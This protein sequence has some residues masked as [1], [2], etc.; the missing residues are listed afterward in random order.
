M[1]ITREVS[2]SPRSLGVLPRHRDLYYGGAWQPALSGAHLELTNPATAEGLGVV[3]AAGPEDVDRAV[4]AAH[5]AF[6]DWKR[7]KPAERA[8]LLKAVADCMRKHADELGWIES[9]D[10][11]TAYHKA[12]DEAAAAADVIEYFAG[13]YTELKGETIPM[14][15]GVLNYSLREPFGVVARINAFNHPVMFAGMKL[16]PALMA[17][18]T[19]IIKPAEQAPLS[20]LRLAELLDGMLPPGVFNVLTGGPDAGEALVRHPV[21]P[22]IGVIGSIKTGQAVLRAAADGIKRVTL[23]LGGKNALIAFADADPEK[24]AAAAVFGLSLERGCGQACSSNTRLFLHD[25]IHD[26]VVE[27]I[28][29]RL[30]RLRVGLPT[31]ERTEVGCLVSHAQKERV[32]AYVRS[33]VEQGATLVTGGNAPGGELAKGAFVMPTLF[34]GVTSEMAIAREEIF[35]PVLATLRWHDEDAM[36][37]AVNDVGYGLAAS[38]WT[39]SL[40]AAHRAAER[41]DVG[42]VWINGTL[43]HRLGAQFGGHKLSGLGVEE[44]LEELISYTQPKNVHVTFRM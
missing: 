30:T 41:V 23:E 22:R 31:D 40:D 43:V 32:L 29:R 27:S 37:D 28:A 3:A 38:I 15:D 44:C 19:V 6:R 35:G 20:V 18:N 9:I 34:T 8:R 17:G 12:R 26:E 24:V 2:S 14:G 11:G 7:V 33:G 4:S 16:A 5:A 39:R 13:F 36:F 42:Y 10:A 21:V 1:T 25:A